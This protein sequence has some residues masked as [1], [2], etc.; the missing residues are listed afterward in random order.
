M[1]TLLLGTNWKQNKK[2]ILNSLADDV[3]NMQGGRILMVPELISHQT[4]RDL[5]S[6]AGNTASR[7]AEVLS[8]SRL[9]KRVAEEEGKV[10]PDCL[11]DGGRVVAMA[12]ATRQ[13]HSKLKAYASVETKP[14]FLK[15]LLD[16]VDE[17]KRCCITPGEL[18]E[19][20]CK[21]EGGL[22]QKLEELSLILEAY[23]SICMNGKRD[24]RDQMTWLLELLEDCDYASRHVFYFD[25]FPAFSRQHME[26]LY[27]LIRFSP[28]V[29][30]SLN[31][32][33]PGS[34]TMAFEE[35][36]ATAGDILAFAIGNQIPYRIQYMESENT[37]LQNVADFLFQG[38]LK[39]GIASEQLCVY[40]TESVYDA[41]CEIAEQVIAGVQSGHRYRDFNVVCTDL[42]GFQGTLESVLERANIPV[43]LSGTEDIL[44]K[45]VIHTVLSAMD[46]ALGGFE[47]KDV[48][49]YLKSMLSPISLDTVD[50]MEN[51]AILWSVNG[52][53]WMKPWENHPRGLGET[54]SEYD[55]IQLNILNEAREKAMKPL[56]L[57]RDRFHCAVGVQQQ[58]NALYGFLEDIKLH[59]RLQVMAS[60][61][62]AKAD[63]R[64]AQILNQL[65]EILVG[66]LEQLHDVLADATWDAE[67]FSKLLKLLL[68]CYDVGTIPAVLDAVKIGS[69]SAMRCEQCSH[70]FLM[71]A[72]EGLLPT[73]GTSSG[74]LSD[75]E[76]S[77]LQKLGVP[78]NPGAIEGL[79]TQFSEIQEVFCGASCSIS[80]FC[81]DGQPSYVYNRLKTM[82]GKEIN[83]KP[84]FGPA[85][86]NA[87]EAAA[88][89]S[90]NKLEHEADGLQIRQE[91][92]QIA[93]C[94]DH[95]L[96]SIEPEHVSDLYGT[97]LNLSASQI[98][99]MAECRLHYFLRYGIRAKERKAAGVDPAEFGT[100]VH[101]VLEECGKQIVSHGGFRNVSLEQT[102]Q[103]A[104][105]ASAKYFAERFSQ[106]GTERMQYHFRRNSKEVESIVTELWKEMQESSFDAAEFELHFGEDGEMP[107]VSIP[108]CKMDAQLGG[109]V[110]RV[111]RWDQNGITYVRV[112]DYKTGK[113]DFDYCDIY[114]GIGLQMLLYL[115]ALEDGGRA[116]F[117]DTPVA[118][119]VQ[120]FPARMPFINADGTMT[121]EEAHA[122]HMKKLK[123]QGLLLND[124]QVLYAVEHNDPPKR[125]PVKK[126]RDG[127]LSGDIASSHQFVLL[128]KYIYKLL[129]DIVNEIASGNVTP[130]P[131]TR[132]TA[133][134]ACQYCPYGTI[135]HSEDVPDRRNYKTMSSDR[136]WSE[137]EKGEGENG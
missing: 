38:K 57:L 20:S 103:L 15:G 89:L 69:V 123:R 42:A 41:C 21:T 84:Q 87:W 12:A 58:V 130:N 46:A 65:W 49:R 16:A 60:D 116:V 109:F 64:N 5:A 3:K 36:G 80:V 126:N 107:P 10:L 28:N 47:Q 85:L 115:Y 113:K 111:D 68:S 81:M 74:V 78:I 82:A 124:E 137:I 26:I 100:Y 129:R 132:G 9:A 67:T 30:V 76:R 50:R 27:H 135:C 40:R 1:L 125:I 35:S 73:Y 66:A 79:Q 17:F 31:C 29:V 112:V 117:G 71:G 51:Y 88:V 25:G 136:F 102:L 128:K 70:L 62:D 7:Y 2:Y 48:L 121:E 108:G 83:A 92:S 90:K 13:L 34:E 24:P 32:D 122:E 18:M 6:Y 19:A 97:K 39:E 37:P 22:A 23:N 75:Q 96:G 131:Y 134:S 104:S 54:W 95:C 91:V 14:E 133:R 86:T 119:G 63:H 33:K 8:F 93:S 53:A 105:D 118:A 59:K 43:Y 11:D 45:N 114:N 44:E 55:K 4:E 94:K 106:I 52:S 77:A 99:R 101:A 110:D 56:A 61:M 127:I 120:Y 72:S 98:D